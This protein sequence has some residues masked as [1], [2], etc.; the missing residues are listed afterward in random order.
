MYLFVGT[1]G[2]LF[3]RYSVFPTCADAG[4]L[5]FGRIMRFTGPRMSNVPFKCFS[6]WHTYEYELLL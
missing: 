6:S 2:T 4:V 5:L 1:K 3:V